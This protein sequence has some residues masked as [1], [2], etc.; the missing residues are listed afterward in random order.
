MCVRDV[1]VCVCV[2]KRACVRARVCLVAPAPVAA[3]ARVGPNQHCHR[4]WWLPAWVAGDLVCVVVGGQLLGACALVLLCW[5]RRFVLGT[6][7]AICAC[8]LC[9]GVGSCD[10]LLACSFPVFLLACSSCS[11]GDVPLPPSW[12]STAWPAAWSAAWSLAGPPRPAPYPRWSEVG[13]WGT[14]LLIPLSY[15]TAGPRC[16]LVPGAGVLCMD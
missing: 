13:G 7:Y 15:F 3:F 14:L 6:V 12:S 16:C 10:S 8:A 9:Q 11:C 2:C 1:C 4:R 5:C